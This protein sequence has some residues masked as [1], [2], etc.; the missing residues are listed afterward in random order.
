ML[1]GIFG[2]KRD[3]VTEGW[4]MLHNEDLCMSPRVITMIKSMRMIWVRN[5]A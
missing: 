4:R 1:K 2:P 5:V 3:E